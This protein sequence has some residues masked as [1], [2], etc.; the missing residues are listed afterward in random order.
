MGKPN[1]RQAKNIESLLAL[2]EHPR[3]SEEERD[4]GRRALKR[5]YDAL[6]M[7]DVDESS[8]DRWLYNPG[9]WKGSKY[10]EAK[11]L[12]L[13]E[14]AKLIRADLK[15][16]RKIGQK[17]TDPAALAVID[18]MADAPAEI[19]ISVR[20]QYYSGGGAI[21]VTIKNI[22]QEWGWTVQKDDW[23]NDQ[24]IA[25]PAMTA[26]YREVETI[27]QAYNYDNSDVQS[28]YFERNYAGHVSTEP[29]IRIKR[30]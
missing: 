9:A 14:I 5:I 7:H 1:A 4:A 30:W 21:D 24:R 15:L 22:P 13:P 16:A 26:L 18:P 27:H 29:N 10:D 6:K 20:S 2:I 8:E 11:G 3:T 12:S 19:K 23:G 17:I 28:D 25:T